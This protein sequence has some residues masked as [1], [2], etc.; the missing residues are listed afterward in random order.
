MEEIKPSKWCCSQSEA[1][2][3]ANGTRGLESEEASSTCSSQQH[4]KPTHHHWT[5]VLSS[6]THVETMGCSGLKQQRLLLFTRRETLWTS[7]LRLWL[8]NASRLFE[9]EGGKDDERGAYDDWALKRQRI[10]ESLA[11][12]ANTCQTQEV[13][14]PL[15]TA[16]S[17]SWIDLLQQLHWLS[18]PRHLPLWSGNRVQ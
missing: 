8:W 7:R 3:G 12:K 9:G 11:Q 10:M 2:K 18:A 4:A 16:V 6:Q 17:G 15:T 5:D 1:R 13:K 14:G